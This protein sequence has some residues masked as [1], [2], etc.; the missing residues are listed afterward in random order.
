MKATG[1]SVAFTQ[2]I[3]TKKKLKHSILTS[4]SCDTVRGC[5]MVHS[6]TA[7]EK[8][9]DGEETHTLAQTNH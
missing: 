1:G 3:K 9:T 8:K 2:V 6:F 5:G 7:T 4:R